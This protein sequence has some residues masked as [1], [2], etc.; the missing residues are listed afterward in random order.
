M[1]IQVRVAAKVLPQP[2]LVVVLTMLMVFVP[3]IA[4]LCYEWIRF[5]ARHIDQPGMRAFMTPAMALQRL[6][7]REPDETQVDVAVR[8]LR[9]V[10]E[11]ERAIMSVP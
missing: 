3:L 9:E 5:A 4:A 10:L 8:A 1:A 11:R 2:A 7:T 6:T